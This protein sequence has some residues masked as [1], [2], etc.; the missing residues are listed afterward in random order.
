MRYLTLLR[1]TSAAEDLTRTD[2]S[3]YAI[4][5]RYGYDSESSLSRAFKR[6]MG[7]APGRYRRSNGPS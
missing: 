6:A 3:L 5:R 7:V 1:L 4:A 2:D